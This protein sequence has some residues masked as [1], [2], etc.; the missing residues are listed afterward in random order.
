MPKAVDT[1]LSFVGRSGCGC[2]YVYRSLWDILCNQ[3]FTQAPPFYPDEEQLFDE[4]RIWYE[5][6]ITMTVTTSP[7]TFTIEIETDNPPKAAD[8]IYFGKKYYIIG[9][10][11]L[12]DTN[13][14]TCSGCISIDVSIIGVYAALTVLNANA[15]EAEEERAQA[16]S[17]REDAED[18]REEAE[19]ARAQAES[20]RALDF[21]MAQAARAQAYQVAEGTKAGSVAGDGS[22][23]G[24]FK[25]AEAARDAELSDYV[26]QTIAP[27]VVPGNIV[28]GV[29]VAEMQEDTP[30]EAIERYNDGLQTQLYLPSG[31]IETIIGADD[32]YLYTLSWKWPFSE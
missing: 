20:E 28:E 25:S 5:G 32:D 8:I 17:D 19:Y 18:D 7:Y 3:L 26:A 22:R 29:F 2:P 9:A 6:D 12:T 13:L 27:W 23:W 30:E 16:E 11:E 1:E 21:N 14:Y 10:V 15:T 24:E 31:R 4:V